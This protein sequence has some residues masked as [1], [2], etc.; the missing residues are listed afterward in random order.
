MRGHRLPVPPGRG[1]SRGWGSP[2]VAQKAGGHRLLYFCRFP[3][4]FGAPW[5]RRSFPLFVSQQRREEEV[6]VLPRKT[7]GKSSPNFSPSWKDSG[8]FREAPS[9]LT[10]SAFLPSLSPFLFRFLWSLSTPDPQSQVER[11]ELH[12]CTAWSSA[13][14]PPLPLHCPLSHLPFLVLWGRNRC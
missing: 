6:G 9:H 7:P 14:D 5:L 8:S 4:L 10:F 11:P 3:Q 13:A 1:T 2:R 12:L